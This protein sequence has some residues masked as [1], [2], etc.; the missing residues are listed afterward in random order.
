MFRRILAA[1]AVALAVAV[2]AVAVAASSGVPH[3]V[4][5]VKALSKTQPPLAVTTLPRRP[6][7]GLTIDIE[8]C[9]IPVCETTTAAAEL[10]WKVDYLNTALTPQA[11][12]QA[13]N[14]MLQQP[15][16][17]IAFTGI[18]PQAL[19][20][21]Q[22]AEAARLKIKM[23]DFAPADGRPPG[24]A[25]VIQG[26]VAFRRDGTL[27]ADI[28]AANAGKPAT[29]GW[30]TDP[31]TQALTAPILSA[32]T[33]ELNATS[34]GTIMQLNESSAD[35]Q[36][37]NLAATVSFLKSNPSVTYLATPDENFF[38]GLPAALTAAG[39]TGVQLVTRTPQAVDLQYLKA[40][41]ELGVVFSENSAAGWRGIDD[42]AEL[43]EGIQP[44]VSVPGYHS[45]FTQANVTAAGWTTVPQVPG[46]PADYLKAW[47]VK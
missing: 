45:I 9:A 3:A 41:Q 32:F 12:T 35:P 17:L 26:A 5:V 46:V 22:I 31:A 30:I 27:M 2:P 7:T 39:I 47:H 38:V 15:P 10:G 23:I 36:P 18:F 25:A 21:K 24:V 37:Q 19:V 33:A 42:L 34:G 11:Y 43:T 6:A 4:A 29:V 13:W 20:A 14:Q 44:Q 16:K 8:T 40:G 1:G 28:V